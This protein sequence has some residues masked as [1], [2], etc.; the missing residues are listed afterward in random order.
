MLTLAATPFVWR[1]HVE[2]GGVTLTPDLS[3]STV[4]VT[5]PDGTLQARNADLLTGTPVLSKAQTLHA[6]MF[7]AAATRGTLVSFGLASG[8]DIHRVHVART[9]WRLSGDP[10]CLTV[11]G[12][13]ISE[14]TAWSSHLPTGDKFDLGAAIIVILNPVETASMVGVDLKNAVSDD[15]LTGT[16]TV[17]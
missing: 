5:M 2:E 1:P 12:R 14:A 8:G 7:F 16:F 17:S 6:V 4:S 15:A 9:A 10:L 3:I 13:T 11:N